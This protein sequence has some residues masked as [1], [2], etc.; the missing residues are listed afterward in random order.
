MGSPANKSSRWMKGLNSESIRLCSGRQRGRATC[1]IAKEMGGVVF[2]QVLRDKTR[3]RKHHS[4]TT[5]ICQRVDG[6]HLLKEI[7][8]ELFFSGIHE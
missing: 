7:W 3:L 6:K 2:P 5:Q 1:S 4:Q 8:V